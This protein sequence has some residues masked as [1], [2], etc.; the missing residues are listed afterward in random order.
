MKLLVCLLSCCASAAAAEP[1]VSFTDDPPAIEV[2]A[3]A[4]PPVIGVRYG[5]TLD[6]ASLK[7]TLNDEV[8]SS[9]FTPAPGASETVELPFVPGP[10][11]LE[12]EAWSLAVA[13]AE[14]VRELVVRELT[15]ARL[16]SDAQAGDRLKSLPE[17]RAER[18]RATTPEA[19][20]P[21]A[22]PAA[23]RRP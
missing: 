4:A 7:V 20:R 17:L 5:T 14:P 3:L 9:A 13:G 19:E 8:V 22:P 12:F 1:L 6:P 23:E 10:N 18:F 21:A 11:R 16:P 15:Y 2:R